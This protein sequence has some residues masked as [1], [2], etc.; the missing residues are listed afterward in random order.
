MILLFALENK[1]DCALCQNGSRGEVSHIIPAFVYKYLKKSSATGYMRKP[2]DPNRRIQ[3]GFKYPLLCESCED[4][5]SI[6][7]GA[8]ASSIFHP[9]L[10]D[11][12]LTISYDQNCLK[13]AVSVLWRGLHHLWKEEDVSGSFICGW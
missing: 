3:D 1:M 13:F 7:E 11:K 12:P 2:A 10:K 4:R 9:Y 8:F 6:Y 5:F